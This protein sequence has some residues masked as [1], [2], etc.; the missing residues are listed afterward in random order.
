MTTLNE[1]I[2]EQRQLKR[3]VRWLEI[4]ESKLGHDGLGLLRKTRADLRA[5]KEQIAKEEG[6]K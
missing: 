2:E 5:V 1:L 6:G 4:R 3:F